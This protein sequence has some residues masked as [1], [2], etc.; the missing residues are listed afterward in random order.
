MSTGVITTRVP[1]EFGPPPGEAGQA[2]ALNGDGDL[3]PTG[4]ELLS[5]GQ[6][7]SY[8]ANGDLVPN[9]SGATL[10]TLWERDGDGNLTPAD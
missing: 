5:A 7:W 8:D 3:V 6:A 2:W 9:D 4:N 1:E 10:E